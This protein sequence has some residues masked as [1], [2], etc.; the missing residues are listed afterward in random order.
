M[1][2]ILFYVLLFIVTGLHAQ[3]K[4]GYIR[5]AMKM[6]AKGSELSQQLFGLTETKM[7]FKNGKSLSVT[8]TP[9]T[10][11]KV[12]NDEKGMLMLTEAG[13]YK[14]FVRKSRAELDQAKKKSMESKKAQIDIV[15]T[16]E[17]KTIL[18][19][20]CTKAIIT[21]A[22]APGKDNKF[23]VWFTEKISNAQGIT[24]NYSDA[25]T[26][27]KGMPLEFDMDKNGTK[28]QMTVKEI[29]S[30][31]VPDATFVLSTAGYT[32]KDARD[33]KKSFR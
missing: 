1:K 21:S 11:M 13:D 8:S 24:Q 18:G 2:K 5:Y 16:Q 28:I 31:P 25:L 29:S 15:Y 3:L 27:L 19:Y 17:K 23:I 6:D 7:Y 22:G 20:P 26:K 32:E 33:L 14:I 9:L 30:K 10:T 12:L 4:E